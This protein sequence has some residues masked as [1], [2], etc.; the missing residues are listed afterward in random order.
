MLEFQNLIKARKT[1]FFWNILLQNLLVKVI[2][3]FILKDLN[4]MKKKSILRFRIKG[5]KNIIVSR[6]YLRNS[7]KKN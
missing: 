1:D 2:C 5:Y 6:M 4:Q 7:G 3:K